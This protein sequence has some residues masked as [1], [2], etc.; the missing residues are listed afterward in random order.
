MK[1]IDLWPGGPR[2]SSRLGR[3][4]DTELA[5]GDVAHDKWQFKSKR[6]IRG[7]FI[8]NQKIRRINR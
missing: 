7:V 2:E 8:S 1:L 3:E 6:G 5:D 4:S